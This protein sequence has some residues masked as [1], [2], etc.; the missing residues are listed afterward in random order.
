MYCPQGM[1]NNISTKRAQFCAE[2]RLALF[3]SDCRKKSVRNCESPASASL[4]TTSLFL[5]T[6]SLN[7]PRFSPS[8]SLSLSLSL[9]SC[10]P[11]PPSSNP[12]HR[13]SHLLSPP[14]STSNPDRAPLL[15]LPLHLRLLLPLPH[16]LVVL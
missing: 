15:P 1:R 3:R 12:F 2:K 10:S 5:Q 7:L 6:H 14:H 16:L 8:L 9:S 13:D 11:S 4:F